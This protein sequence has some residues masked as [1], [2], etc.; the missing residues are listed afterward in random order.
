M[1]DDD[2]KKIKVKRISDI[3][4]PG[5][6]APAGTSKPV[7]VGN[8]PIVKDPMMT[9]ASTASAP[10]ELTDVS[11][12]SPDSPPAAGPAVVHKA[13]VLTPSADAEAA[14][15]ES[16]VS[17]P[18][19]N[20]PPAADPK[21]EAAPAPAEASATDGDAAEKKPAAAE[22]EASD[23]DQP[24]QPTPDDTA[25][26]EAKKQAEHDAAIEK[27]AAGKQY[28]LPINMVEKRRTK[29]FVA[30]GVVLAVV[31][32]LVWVDVA[33][34]AG[35]IHLAGIKPVTHFFSS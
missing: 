3:T 16:E 31:L 28:F 14:A 26:A 12:E 27:L 6:S 4:A 21:P 34:D 25:K 9:G 19:N 20:R 15:A 11:A 2:A 32:A 22:N 23:G 35:L 13:L 8:R 30:L 7:I 18:A 24:D 10:S 33:L 17:L 5:K 29:Q 1:A